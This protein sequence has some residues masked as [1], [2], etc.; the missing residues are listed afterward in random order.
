MKKVLVTGANGAIGYHLSKR[1]SQDPNVSLT[2]VDNFVNSRMDKDMQDII[3]MDNVNFLQIN[4]L[5]LKSIEEGLSQN[6]DLVFHTAAMNGTSL[7]Y[8]KPFEVIKNNALSTVNLLTVLGKRISE[9]FV[10]FGTSE[11][12]AAGVDMGI[13]N[14]PTG[15]DAVLVIDDILNPRWSYS[16]SKVL[17]ESAC[18]ASSI[19][20]GL[21]FTILR[22]HNSFGPRMGPKHFISQFTAKAING[23]FSLK[24]GDQTRSFVFVEDVVSAILLSV[25]SKQTLNNI[26]NIGAPTERKVEDVARIIL[27]VL[28]LEGKEFLNLP[29]P[30]GSV[31]RRCPDVSFLRSLGFTEYTDFEKSIEETVK[32]IVLKSKEDK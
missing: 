27:K 3:N 30:E 4:L 16:S 1:L 17:G 22:I 29:A 13:N 19:Q 26:I 24:G 32:F 20:D 23:D 31:K 25:D 10:Y 12:Y 11:S 5:D 8:E 28:G 21:P 14:V 6:F 9:R 7:F 2:I 18:V 15:E